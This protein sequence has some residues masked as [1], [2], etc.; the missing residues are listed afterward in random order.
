MTY[1]FD[2]ETTAGNPTF[3]SRAVNSLYGTAIYGVSYY[4]FPNNYTFDT[5]K[6]SSNYSFD[7]EA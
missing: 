4:G 5:E 1:T 7:N 3:D 6:G 2:T